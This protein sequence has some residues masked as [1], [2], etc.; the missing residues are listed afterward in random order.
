MLAK[1]RTLIITQFFFSPPLGPKPRRGG[2]GDAGG[3]AVVGAG[4]LDAAAAEDLDAALAGGDDDLLEV[5]ADGAVDEE[6]EAGVDD[7]EP[8]VERRH[9]QEPH[10]RP[11]RWKRQNFFVE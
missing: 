5:G 1:R 7:E 6:V 10:R 8:V 2:L 9:A 11:E 4:R 3:V